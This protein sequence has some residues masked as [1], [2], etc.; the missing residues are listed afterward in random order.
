MELLVVLAVCVAVIGYTRHEA[1]E[2][3][4]SGFG[5]AFLGTVG[6]VVGFL[7][8]ALSGGLFLGQPGESA[9]PAMLGVV[10]MLFGPIAGT[11]V[12]LLWVMALSDGIPYVGGTRWRMHCMSTADTPGF[13]CELAV[14][15]GQV[16]VG[17]RFAIAS[18]DLTDIGVDGECLRLGWGEQSL[19][20]LPLER[21]GQGDGTARARMK[22][23]LGLQRRL[24]RLLHK[25][26]R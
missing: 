23:S 13:T 21:E 15:G 8:G 6:G 22:R 3:G 14:V 1:V 7:L 20:L 17:E 4:R 26:A 18:A 5:W 16:R 19:L 10:V 25:T 2:R 9:S 24:R 12:A 11:T